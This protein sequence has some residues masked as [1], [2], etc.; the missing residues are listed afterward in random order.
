[1]RDKPCVCQL[2]RLLAVLASTRETGRHVPCSLVT[3]D[4]LQYMFQL[5]SKTASNDICATVQ[6]VLL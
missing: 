1:V 6:S 4:W 2:A 3:A 5:N